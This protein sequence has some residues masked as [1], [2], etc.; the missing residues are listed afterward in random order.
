MYGRPQV[1]STSQEAELEEEAKELMKE[2][3]AEEEGELEIGREEE[4]EEL[5]LELEELDGRDEVAGEEEDEVQR[6]L[7]V[8]TQPLPGLQLSLVHAL[9]SL[10][11]SIPPPTQPL[12]VKNIGLHII[13]RV[14]VF[15]SSGQSASV[16]QTPV[17]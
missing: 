1:A 13:G 5:E 12:E 7:G 14:Q 15:P 10:Q 16:V 4:L 8:F 17:E 9:L 11:F 6:L 3:D 2:D